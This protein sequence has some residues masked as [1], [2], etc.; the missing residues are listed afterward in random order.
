MIFIAWDIFGVASWHATN[1]R[2]RHGKR[3]EVD[4]EADQMLPKKVIGKRKP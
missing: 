3:T 1:F 4:F 2:N